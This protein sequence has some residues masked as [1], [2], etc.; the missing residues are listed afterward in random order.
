[1]EAIE[2]TTIAH[3]G[4]TY[5]IRVFQDP[6]AANP[7][8]EWSEMG[9]ILSLSHRH[10]NFD[11][12]GVK[13]AIEC[14]P[15]AVPL[16]YFEHGMCLWA[17]A[18]EL[19]AGPACPWDSVGFAGIWLP[20]EETLASACNYGGRTRRLFM[21]K[22][23]RQACHAYTQ[24]CND[25]VY[26]YEIERVTVCPHCASET[27]EP[28]D[29]CWGFFGLEYCLGEAKAGAQTLMAGLHRPTLENHDYSD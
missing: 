9:T 16:S 18:G 22:R 25:E 11:P 1:M 24:W 8:D 14:N 28:V 21:R 20:D 26:G 17:V 5:R 27:T 19:P 7:L 2:T 15:D 6:D 29:S 10:S 13:E 23:A 4:Q 12:D 3:D